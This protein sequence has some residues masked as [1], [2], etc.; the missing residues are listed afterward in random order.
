LKEF[1]N[2]WQSQEQEGRL[3]QMTCEPKHC[4]VE[5][6]TYQRSDIWKAVVRAS[7][8]SNRPHWSH[9]WDQQVL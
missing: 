1:F 2:I 7:S 8:Y 4:P 6:Q 5:R 3:P 9:I